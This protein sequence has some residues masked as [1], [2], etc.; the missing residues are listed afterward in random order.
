MLAKKRIYIA[1][2]LVF[3]AAVYRG[4]VA[5][6]TSSLKLVL[7]PVSQNRKIP[8]TASYDVAF[9][10]TI[11][12][13]TWSSAWVPSSR[14]LGEK[15]KESFP[16]ATKAEKS[17]TKKILFYT[18]FFTEGWQ[19]FLGNRTNLTLHGC[20]ETRCVFT[21]DRDGDQDDADALIFHANDFDA[22]AVPRARRPHQKYVWFNLEAPVPLQSHQRGR[23]FFNWT[24]SYNRD[25]DLFLPY[26]V[27]TPLQAEVHDLTGRPSLLD[28]SSTTFFKYMQD[29]NNNVSLEDDLKYDWSSFLRRPKI[30]AWMVSNCR[31]W[32]GRERYVKELQRYVQVDVYG[33]CGTLVCDKNHRDTHCYT[34]VLSVNY[35]FYLSFE[36]SLCRDYITEK[37][38]FPML[39]GLV[40]VVYGGATYTDY[41]PPNSYIDARTMSPRDLAVLLVKLSNSRTEYA[42]YHLWRQHWKV[43]PFPPLCELCFKLHRESSVTTVVDLKAWWS[44]VNNCSYLQPSSASGVESFSEK[45]SGAAKMLT[46]W[47]KTALQVIP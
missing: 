34:D 7:T 18:K 5:D 14:T 44:S 13:S 43:T 32:S 8:T 38:W 11:S 29:L 27:L 31:T 30:A 2:P 37:V 40:P 19:T 36:N 33:K 10:D 12:N 9:E 42:R 24:F 16:N 41:L 4:L 3:M 21:F 15:T 17:E 6:Y 39:H 23:D 28:K 22:K 47:A 20:P 1:L 26:G 35:L 46:L 25:S 45:L